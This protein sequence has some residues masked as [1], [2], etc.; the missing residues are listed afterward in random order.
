MMQCV[1]QMLY[2]ICIILVF[3]SCTKKNNKDLYN[4]SFKFVNSIL[5][6]KEN[7]FLETVNSEKLCKNIDSRIKENKEELYIS[8][9]NIFVYFRLKYAL[10]KTKQKSIPVKVEIKNI[11][12]T[13][14]TYQYEVYWHNAGISY[15]IILKV[16]K[17][18]FK[19]EIIDAYW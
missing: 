15:N 9:E 17:R 7:L 16:E 4:L 11:H 1:K 6:D 13:L 10:M 2:Y 8:T 18:F 14:G 3:L 12:K 19:F 5:S